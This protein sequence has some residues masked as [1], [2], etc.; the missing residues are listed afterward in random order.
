MRVDSR[1]SGG[2]R[3]WRLRWCGRVRVRVR[4][5]ST[6]GYARVSINWNMRWQQQNNPKKK[7][8]IKKE[9]KKKKKKKKAKS[10][11][12]NKRIKDKTHARVHRETETGRRTQAQLLR[13]TTATFATYQRELFVR[14]R[15]SQLR[16]SSS[17]ASISVALLSANHD[18]FVPWSMT[19]NRVQ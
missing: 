11:G 10:Q 15:T 9:G 14:Q 2:W 8:I 1:G 6:C 5:Q 17:A 12:K 19:S 3:G 18:M 16:Q 7:N 4:V 13:I